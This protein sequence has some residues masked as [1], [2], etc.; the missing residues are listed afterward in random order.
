LSPNEAKKIKLKNIRK[1]KKLLLF[2]SGLFT[3]SGDLTGI[4]F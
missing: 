2:F 4:R 3:K 1:D